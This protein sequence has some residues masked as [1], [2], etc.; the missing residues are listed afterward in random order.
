MDYKAYDRLQLSLTAIGCNFSFDCKKHL[1]SVADDETRAALS[2]IC[3][4]TENAI[5][6]LARSIAEALSAAAK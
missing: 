5:N 4:S 6:E 2:A 1:N 3:K